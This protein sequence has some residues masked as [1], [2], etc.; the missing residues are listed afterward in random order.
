MI[1]AQIKNGKVQNTIVLM[2]TSL[3]SQFSEGFDYFIEIDQL[4]PVPGVGWG[5]D[6]AIFT[7]PMAPKTPKLYSSLSV[8]P[9]SAEQG[10]LAITVDTQTKYVYNSGNWDQLGILGS[11]SLALIN[12]LKLT[13][14]IIS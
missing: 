9:N 3:V 13:Q 8:L 14:S 1:Y 7:A 6:G 4:S 2:D 10:D 5:Y 12:R 11:I